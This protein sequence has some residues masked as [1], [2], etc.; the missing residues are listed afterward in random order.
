MQKTNDDG[1]YSLTDMWKSD[2]ANQSNKPAHWLKTDRIKQLIETIG[3]LRKGNDPY[4]YLL[5][6][7]P[8]RYGGTWACK[9]LVIAYAEYLSPEFHLAVIKTFEL[10]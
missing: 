4:L 6:T 9:E 2:G 8:G 5:K 3:K 1:M 7:T 10:S